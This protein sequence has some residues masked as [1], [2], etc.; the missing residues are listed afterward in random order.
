MNDEMQHTIRHAR[1]EMVVLR[2]KRI[3]VTLLTLTVGSLLMAIGVEG[4]IDPETT[5]ARQGAQTFEISES[6]NQSMAYFVFLFG[7]TVFVVGGVWIRS[8]QRRIR[9]EAAFLA[10]HDASEEGD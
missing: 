9:I 7:I 3:Y 2:R 6:E 5:V 4:F 1:K 8:I 10:K